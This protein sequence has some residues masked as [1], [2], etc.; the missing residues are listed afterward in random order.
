M[1]EH[2]IFKEIEDDLERQK[3]ADLWKRYGG[4]VIAAALIIVLTT[5]GITFWRNW[6]LERNETATAE[7]I[8]IMSQE[9]EGSTKQIAALENLATSRDGTMQAAFA[10]FQVA[11]YALKDGN[12]EK[13]LQTYDAIAADTRVDPAFRQLADLFAVQAQLDTGPTP[14]LQKRLQPLLAENAPWRYTAM[15]FSGYLALRDGDKSKAKQIF[16]ELSQNAKVPP[17]LGQRSADILRGIGE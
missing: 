14:V 9:G 3:Y 11:A 15:E 6:K 8:A 17:S 5:G 13:A 12:K 2:N 7:L 10:K 1:T 16:T 4:L